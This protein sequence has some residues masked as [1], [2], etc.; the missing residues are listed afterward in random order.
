MHM[1]L[2]V[3]MLFSKKSPQG[4]ITILGHRGGTIRLNYNVASK[5]VLI[6]T[7]NGEQGYN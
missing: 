6:R 5:K 7:F 1:L 4:G 2:N 3:K